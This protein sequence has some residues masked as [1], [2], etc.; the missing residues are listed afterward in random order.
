MIALGNN[1]LQKKSE[2]TEIELGKPLNV[3]SQEHWKDPSSEDINHTFDKDNNSDESSKTWLS[4]PKVQ[5]ALRVVMILVA[6]IAL[7]LASFAPGMLPEEH[8][9]WIKDEFFTHTESINQYF[10]DHPKVKN[11]FLIFCSLWMDI[12]MVTGMVVFVIY[13]K[14]WRLP[15]ALIMFYLLRMIIQKLFLLRYPEGYLWSYPGFPSLVVPYG[16]TN[17]F[18]YSGH[19]G[20]ACV[21]MLEFRS[22]ANTQVQNRVFM[23][24]MQIF[25]IL[26]II[27]QVFLMIFL[28]GHYSID[29][30]SGI[31]FGHYFHMIASDVSPGWDQ[32]VCGIP[33]DGSESNYNMFIKR[34]GPSI[35]QKPR[36]SRYSNTFEKSES[37]NN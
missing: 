13:G 29:M 5:L 11:V 15:I 31:I 20:G 34:S 9:T 3:K 8:I 7:S 27:L 2:E 16:K 33:G 37:V 12:T 35:V 22:L 18:F 19:V 14:T 10:G 26:T 32:A 4:S 21:M 6:V 28:R 30:I 23:R 1:G 17:D 36:Q 25:A 24:W